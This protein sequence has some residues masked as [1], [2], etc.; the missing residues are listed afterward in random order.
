M[1]IIYDEESGGLALQSEFCE[2][3]TRPLY[4]TGCDAPGCH[5]LCCMECG[6]G[7]DIDLDDTGRCATALAGE[8]DEDYDARVN[9]ERAAFGLSP[10]AAEAGGEPQ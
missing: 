3:C 1:P 2:D 4:D 5:G 6:T 7:C 10:L 9:A 8:S